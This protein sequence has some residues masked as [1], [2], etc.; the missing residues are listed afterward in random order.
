MLLDAAAGRAVMDISVIIGTYNRCESLIKSVRSIILMH[1]P[2]GVSW[3]LIVVDNNSTDKTREQV[4]NLGRNTTV[5]MHYVLEERQGLSYAR[6]RGIEESKGKIIAFLD[7]DCIVDPYWLSRLVNEF[8]ADPELHGIG[9]RVELYDK[10]DKPVTI[11]TSRD[12]RL[13]TS[14]GQLFSFMHGCNMAFVR[15]VFENTGV[16]DIR[17]G[18]GTKI[19]AAEDADFIYRVY[20]SG[21]KMLYCPELLVYHNHGRRLDAQVATLL[22]GYTIGRGAFYSKHIVQGDSVMLKMAYWE[23]S[24]LL[25]AV[26]KG[27]YG[28]WTRPKTVNYLRDLFVGGCYYTFF[29]QRREGVL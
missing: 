8:H 11:M 21:F 27:S 22:R 13:F 12:R 17:L 25:K 2:D 28:N 20:K 1:V 23:L 24:A 29:R 10:R 3:E 14:A 7:D 15:T 4:S 6:N 19:L 9:G 26:L 16:F 5:D 18:P